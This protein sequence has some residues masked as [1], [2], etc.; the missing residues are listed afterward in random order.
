LMFW[1]FLYVIVDRN[2]GVIDS[3]RIAQETTSGTYGVVFILFLAGAGIQILGVFPGLCIGLL[4]TTPF[5]M[6][7]WAV[8]YCV[9]SGK[10]VPKT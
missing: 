1:P 5:W 8:T 7:M 10:P 3:L 6:L 9:I 2:E 4:F